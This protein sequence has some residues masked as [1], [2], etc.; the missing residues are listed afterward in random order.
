MS[1]AAEKKL[2]EVICGKRGCWTKRKLEDAG[3][4]AD[5]KG[6]WQI[7]EL[8]RHFS[9]CVKESERLGELCDGVAVLPQD[10]NRMLRM[11]ELKAGLEDLPKA[12]SQLR[13]GT[14]LV[15]EKLGRDFHN[16]KV[17][18]EIHVG[19]APQNTIK[20]MQM[21]EAEGKRYRVVAFKDGV[22]I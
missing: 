2:K 21:V 14:E 17:S 10:S 12:K 19:R 8:D 13:K 1:K 4:V 11:L 3:V 20:G 16:Q 9:A 22:K 7:L 6:P 5:L 18:L 15:S